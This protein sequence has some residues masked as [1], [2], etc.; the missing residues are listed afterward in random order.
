MAAPWRRLHFEGGGLAR[1]AIDRPRQRGA[2][3]GVD[4]ELVGGAGERDVGLLAVDELDAVAGVEGGEDAADGR[5]LRRVGGD[6][7]GVVERLGTA[8]AREGDRAPAAAFE[9]EDEAAGGGGL[10]HRGGGAVGDAAQAIGAAELHAV[11]GGEVAG[12]GARQVAAAQAPRV[13]VEDGAVAVALDA[14]GVALGIDSEDA[15]GVAGADAA[16][17]GGL[18][19]GDD[20]ADLV[21]ADLGALGAGQ[22]LGDGHRD[23]YRLGG[24]AA[25]GEQLAAGEE[26]QVTALGVAGG[27]HQRLARRGHELLD[28]GGVAVAGGGDLDDVAAGVEVADG[29][30]GAAG[31]GELHRGEQVGV[32]LAADEV[33]LHGA[34]AGGLEGGPRRARRQDG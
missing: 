24:D 15:G 19:I 10:A 27:D 1:L 5:A 16:G 18:H 31:G 30:G 29:V 13:V 2:V 32:L 11:A 9:L 3:V 28:H 4:L 26:V 23:G 21:M 25:G 8:A 22:P 6:G 14:E 33:E 12:L 34:E 20:V 17:R 7:V